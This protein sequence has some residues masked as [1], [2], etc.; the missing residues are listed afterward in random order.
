M[1][2]R[3]PERDFM[4]F[5]HQNFKRAEA[6][7]TIPATGNTEPV[8]RSAS[9]TRPST[10]PDRPWHSTE[11]ALLGTDGFDLN[12]AVQDPVITPGASLVLNPTLASKR[13]PQAWRGAQ[14]LLRQGRAYLAG[15]L[16]S[17][18]AEMK[19]VGAFD[20]NQQKSS[21]LKAFV[22]LEEYSNAKTRDR[23]KRSFQ[24][25]R[26][27]YFERMDPLSEEDVSAPFLE[28]PEAYAVFRDLE[29][30]CKSKWVNLEEAEF[31][32]AFHSEQPVVEV[33]S[34]SYCERFRYPPEHLPLLRVGD[35]RL[36]RNGKR[37]VCRTMHRDRGFIAIEFLTPR[38][39]RHFEDTG[40]YMRTVPH[41]C[42]DCELAWY[43][44]QLYFACRTDQVGATSAI[45]RF[46]VAC[47]EGAY[48]KRTMLP[49]MLGVNTLS[50]IVGMVPTFS[51]K[52]RAYVPI[53]NA[54]DAY[55]VVEINVGF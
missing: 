20:T 27:R 9:L 39:N 51:D 44:E 7:H 32:K 2:G 38:E 16:A 8:P 18:R 34:P 1:A 43:T 55:R 24:E 25:S 31:D 10:D 23:A 41:L 36:C 45:N 12:R 5:R 4:D 33:V 28:R 37:C 3:V 11:S 42:V 30:R 15:T 50:G 35:R 13:S 17:L 48:S 46:R 29:A 19:S 40:T 22:P 54:T 21:V 6:Y 47:E 52:Y 53:E 26:D 14:M 49:T